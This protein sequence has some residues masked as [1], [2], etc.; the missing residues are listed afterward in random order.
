MAR[1]EIER[2]EEPF[3]RGVT[4]AASPIS[5][6]GTTWR[7][8]RLGDTRWQMEA[9]RHFDICGE[10]RFATNWMANAISRCRLYVSELDKYGR[11]EAETK[12]DAVQVLAET[13]FGG[14]TLKA[15]AQRALGAQLYLTGESFIIAEEVANASKD[16]WYICSTS[17]VHRN[18]T[19][20]VLVDRSHMYGGGQHEMR[21]GRDLMMRVWTPH[22]RRYDAAD[23]SVRAVLPILREI[24]GLTKKVFAQIDSRLAGAGMLFLPQEL[25]FPKTDKDPP[26]ATGLTAL[27]LRN[28]AAALNDQS[29]SAALVPVIVQIA[30]ELIDKIKWQT[31]ETPFQAETGQKL[32]DAIRR[33]ATGLDIPPEVLLGQGDTNHWSA[34]QIEESTIKIQVE[35]LLVR[36]CDA[37]TNGYLKPALKIIGKDPEAFV[38]WYDTAPLAIRPNRQADAITLYGLAPDMIS[39]EE[40]RAAGDW[41]ESAAPN[42]KEYEKRLALDMVKLNPALLSNPDV[43]KALGIKWK[44]EDPNAAP[45]PGDQPVGPD[46]QPLPPDQ[47]QQGLPPAEQGGSSGGWMQGQDQ[48]ALPQGGE[49]AFATT[50]GA[51]LVGADMVVRRALERGGA[52][53]LTRAR[54]GEFTS[55]PAGELHVHVKPDAAE[56]GRV[57]SDAFEPAADLA[58]RVGMD[59]A[60]VTD[61]LTVYTTSLMAQGIPHDYAR[62]ALYVDQA[63]DLIGHSG[64]ETFCRNPLHP[65]PCAKFHPGKVAKVAPGRREP[66]AGPGRPAKKA[67]KKA[68]DAPTGDRPTAAEARAQENLRTGRRPT[69]RAEPAAPPKTSEQLVKDTASAKRADLGA[70]RTV[71]PGGGKVKGDMAAALGG[72][73]EAA[74]R[75]TEA[76]KATYNFTDPGTGMRAEVVEVFPRPKAPGGKNPGGVGVKIKVFDADGNEVG[77]ATRTWDFDETTGRLDMKHMSLILDEEVQGGGFASRWNAQAQQGYHDMGVGR[78]KLT[79]SDAVG[80]A[81]W[82]SAGYDFL[83]RESMKDVSSAWGRVSK[84]LQPGD[85]LKAKI[86]EMISRSTDADFDAGTHPSPFEWYMVG[87]DEPYPKHIPGRAEPIQSWVGKDIMRGVE[88]AGF[89]SITDPHRPG[90]RR[91]DAGGV[92]AA[93]GDQPPAD[94]LDRTGLSSDMTQEDSDS[95]DERGEFMQAVNGLDRAWADAAADSVPVI[96][97]LFGPPGGTNDYPSHHHLFGADEETNSAYQQL[98]LDLL[99]EW[100]RGEGEGGI[101]AH[102]GCRE[103]QFCRNPLHPGPCKGW[104][105]NLPGAGGG[106]GGTKTAPAPSPSPAPTKAAKAAKKAAGAPAKAAPVPAAVA[107]TPSQAVAA[108]DFSG[109]KRI[110]PQGGSNPGGVFQAADGKKYYIK[111]ASSEDWARQQAATSELYRAAGI[112]SPAITVGQGTPGLPAGWHTAT[113]IIDGLS[114]TGTTPS[115]KTKFKKGV[116]Q[117]FAV[118]AWLADWD[119]GQS[120][121]IMAQSDGSPMRMDIGGSLQYRARGGNKGAAW[122][123]TVGEWSTMRDPKNV[124]GPLFQG[125]SNDELIDSAALVSAVDDATIQAIVKNHKLPASLAATLIQRR[126]DITAKAAALQAL[127]A[128][129]K[130]GNP[131][132]HI[133]ADNGHALAAK[134]IAA[135]KAGN[136]PQARDVFLRSVADEQGFSNPPQ[137]KTSVAIGKMGTA[138]T[139]DVIYRGVSSA[140][141]KTPR[142]IHDE[143]RSGNAYYGRGIYGNGYYFSTNR[144]T[145]TSYAGGRAPGSVVRAAVP[146]TGL[147]KIDWS[148]LQSEWRTYFM[149]L[150]ANDP[151]RSVFQDPGAYAAARGYDVIEVPQGQRVQGRRPETY[152]VILNRTALIVSK[153]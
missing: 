140:A 151:R 152:Y 87:A 44:I 144:A 49:P 69:L 98:T 48:R 67:A 7:T 135:H 31:F 137:I 71:V 35:P 66:D 122:G 95:W 103:D 84:R 121:N 146:L 141:G 10:L 102:A 113:E 90:S 149:A 115:Q 112:P 43:Q 25:D 4:A 75:V 8:W 14:P 81:A 93:A 46:G 12:D 16:I 127:K 2:Y 28:M 40:V 77:N 73:P 139:H 130:T 65:G 150:P 126:D 63:L 15:E 55:I 50:E 134:I 82:A 57:L 128:G 72:D 30:G 80:G 120:G 109:V 47:G 5:L 101:V 79:A 20:A 104:K 21:N 58:E 153:T 45:P 133:A 138:G 42:K 22:P 145:A 26:G 92:S 33:L 39:A 38:V 54:R 17:E 117:G 62:F 97:G 78:I 59:P 123:G 85:P 74:A 106:G 37:L 136:V 125:M 61:M 143:M 91:E 88:W 100:G 96:P 148:T 52:R 27:L 76:A 36:I 118:D 142:Q 111:A 3:E 105:K 11:P 13:M 18:G 32:L 6:D 1:G 107:P 119:I 147:K 60:V 108:G 24:E 129:N 64:C 110:G 68:A 83:D 41:G 56:V 29:S 23:S 114:L 9:W 131:I 53:L 34:W 70:Q 124:S 116:K 19:N 51:L 99:D 86:D 132:D 89:Y 94:A